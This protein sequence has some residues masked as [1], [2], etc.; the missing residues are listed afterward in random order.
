MKGNSVSAMP[1]PEPRPKP[2]ADAAADIASRIEQMELAL[3]TNSTDVEVLLKAAQLCFELERPR[4]MS[5][6]LTRAMG[7]A[8]HRPEPHVLMSGLLRSQGM[9]DD[10]VELLQRA[11]ARNPACAELWRAA[12]GVMVDLQEDDDALTF[13]GEALRLRPELSICREERAA[14]FLRMGRLADALADY[15]ALRAALPH[16]AHILVGWAVVTAAMGDGDAARIACTAALGLARERSIVEDWLRRIETMEID[17]PLE[18]RHLTAADAAPRTADAAPL[19]LAFFHAD[20]GATSAPFAKPDYRA[21]LESAVTAARRTA[22]LAR[23]V[24]LTDSGTAFPERIGFDCIVRRKLDPAQLMYERMRSQREFLASLDDGSNTIFLDSDVVASRDPSG[25]FDGSF[26]IGLT[27]RASQ[28]DAPFNGG[29]ILARA[30]SPALT[31][32]DNMLT[33]YRALERK[34]VIRAR[35]P[36]G[37]RAWWGDQ[38]AMAAT[39]GWKAFARRSSD[40]MSVEGAVVRFLPERP[41]NFVAEGTTP[42]SAP[43][44]INAYFVHFKGLR[45]ARL[46]SYVDRLLQD[47]RA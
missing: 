2:A 14:L 24:L 33:A 32:F 26:D 42:L 31:F 25:I 20:T 36:D 41:Y 27:W 13:Y 29:V 9:H 38:L 12:A 16:V 18:R 39:V 35:F 22:P 11:I 17:L 47:E 15:D 10:A 21:M 8:P 30:A 5:Q 23:L 6:L 7:L 44:R 40:R 37:I 1:A 34:A 19:N 28:P 3:R 43:Q 4:E 46:R 45:K